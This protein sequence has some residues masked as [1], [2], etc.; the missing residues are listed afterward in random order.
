M[1]WIIF[2]LLL[3]IRHSFLFSQSLETIVICDLPA[4]LTESSSLEIDSTGNF[5]S[6]NDSG[7][8]P[9]LYHFNDNG[10]LL[11]TVR[12]TNHSNHDWE[13]I[14]LVGDS[15]IYIGDF[16]NNLNDRQNLR[17]LIVLV[18]NLV[19]GEN[20]VEA[21]EIEFSYSE[22]TLF[23]PGEAEMNFD[24]EAMVCR[25]D[26]LFMFSKNRTVPFTGLTYEY[27]V[28]AIAGVYV[29]SRRDSVWVGADE[30]S[31]RV[32]GA[33]LSDDGKLALLTYTQ[34]LIFE[35]TAGGRFL[36]DDADHYDLSTIS[37]KEA[38]TWA[39]SC[40]LFLSDELLAEFQIGGKLYKTELCDQSVST[41]GTEQYGI[42]VFPQPANDEL[43]ILYVPEIATKKDCIATFRSLDGKVLHS[44]KMK[45]GVV[46]KLDVSI[47]PAGTYLL[48]SDS[49]EFGRG[50]KTIII[51]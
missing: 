24:C 34:V 30:L 40:T 13:D 33:D 22:Q 48:T 8:E 42:R 29:L 45:P 50:R 46:T 47:W 36:E 41:L 19:P 4:E 2:L 5:W 6:S 28:P 51:H 21:G 15:I 25:N 35:E 38:I 12:I 43:N 32:T 11:H 20:F 9:I 49:G 27:A 16:G 44:V 39:D 23:P 3:V 26:S 10:E 18:N 37:Q 14:S 1:K 17:I 7:G 31:G